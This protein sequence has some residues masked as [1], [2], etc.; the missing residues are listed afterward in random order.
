MLVDG[1]PW[2][3]AG[4]Y[5]SSRYFD[6]NAG[7]GIATIDVDLAMHGVRGEQLV[8]T[9]DIDNNPLGIQGSGVIEPLVG[10][11]GTVVVRFPIAL[12]P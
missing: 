12:T 8:V 3:Y 7:P 11:T 6:M 5:D 4:I 9:V 10:D 1:N 2:F